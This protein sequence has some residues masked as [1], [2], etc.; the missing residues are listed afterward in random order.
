[1]CQ[2][3]QRRPHQDYFHHHEHPQK[4]NQ[5]YHQRYFNHQEYQRMP[6]QGYHNQNYDQDCDR[7]H[8][9]AP[10]LK[11]KLP[12]LPKG[13]S[14]VRF[15]QWMNSF[16]TVLKR[17]LV[18]KVDLLFYLQEAMES[19]DL[20]QSIMNFPY[21]EAGYQGAL[22]SLQMRFGDE[23]EL[24]V[25]IYT[26]IEEHKSKVDV[27]SG[28]GLWDLCTLLAS[29][30]CNPLFDDERK[31]NSMLY[32]NIITIFPKHLVRE[33]N[34]RY[35]EDKQDLQTLATWISNLARQHQE[36]DRYA[37]AHP[38]KPREKTS[39]NGN[40]N[41]IAQRRHKYS[42]AGYEKSFQ[43]RDP[44]CKLCKLQ[45][46]TDQCPRLNGTWAEK[47]KVVLDENR[48]TNCLGLH[49]FEECHSGGRCYFCK[50]RHATFLHKNEEENTKVE[51]NHFE[52]EL[53][54]G[55]QV[56]PVSY[57]AHVIPVTIYNISTYKEEETLAYLDW[58]A[59]DSSIHPDLVQKVKLPKIA[60]G[61]NVDVSTITSTKTYEDTDIVEFGISPI[62]EKAKMRQLITRVMPDLPKSTYLD[63][64][65]IKK[66][67]AFLKDVPLKTTLATKVGIQIGRDQPDLLEQIS[68]V[69]GPKNGPRAYQYLLGWALC[70]PMTKQVVN[71]HAQVVPKD[72]EELD[73]MDSPVDENTNKE[74]NK[75]L[76]QDN[77][78]TEEKLAPS[79]EE[80]AFEKA[81]E[82]FDFEDGRPIPGLTFNDKETS[83][84][85]KRLE[86]SN[87][88][89]QRLEMEEELQ[90]SDQ[91]YVEEA[92][93]DDATAQ[94]CI[95]GVDDVLVP[96]S[97]KEVGNPESLKDVD[98][99]T[100]TAIHVMNMEDLKKSELLPECDEQV[101]E[102]IELNIAQQNV[103]ENFMEDKDD[104]MMKTLINEIQATEFNKEYEQLGKEE[105]V[106]TKTQNVSLK[107]HMDEEGSER[108]ISRLEA[109]RNMSEGTAKQWITDNLPNV[110]PR[111]ELTQEKKNSQV[112][113][114]LALDKNLSKSNLKSGR[115]TLVYPGLDGGVRVGDGRDE[116]GDFLQETI[117]HSVPLS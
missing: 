19:E 116:N 79:K 5:G 33:Y 40:D 44:K 96:N 32:T 3:Q 108:C 29:I 60:D 54:T 15:F 56:L 97:I 61:G 105:E 104:A 23:Q 99:S 80:V 18:D 16:K 2:E 73:K 72:E 74:M 36:Y 47:E 39:K 57:S 76:S 81:K 8:H 66:K 86:S 90:A 52:S 13:A 53:P 62:G 48:C 25:A 1:M 77:L 59:Q 91:G 88:K 28:K 11:L 37:R 95:E 102:T 75:K 24:K 51:N 109:T 64:N 101:E 45:H 43:K 41:S 100:D 42:S 107:P 85:L 113:E 22:M 114:V 82:S 31:R 27:R 67:H 30:L 84:A 17:L 68:K 4:P 63:V 46:Y 94:D 12:S 78:L 34:L 49:P 98:N 7:R 26:E 89:L 10:E 38:T 111:P 70:V 69:V 83:L 14:I 58:G 65:D 110:G 106:P 50:G 87:A 112:D 93:A 117:H 115:S 20:K 35:P 55:N 6:E 21:T 9:R 103:D 71:Y 92:D